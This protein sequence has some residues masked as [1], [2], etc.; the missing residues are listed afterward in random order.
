[1]NRIPQTNEDQQFD[2]LQ[3]IREMI[4][5][6]FTEEQLLKLSEK[7]KLPIYM[8]SMAISEMQ[9]KVVK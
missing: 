2:F 8:F 3:A 5:Q 4:S 6:D 9:N 1:M 7:S